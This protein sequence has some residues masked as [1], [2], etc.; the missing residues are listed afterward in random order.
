[1]ASW[2]AQTRRRRPALVRIPWSAPP[3]V[4]STAARPA[5]RAEGDSLWLAYRTQR[6][7]HFAVVRFSGVIEWRTVGSDEGSRRART[8]RRAGFPEPC[9]FQQIEGH[10][11]RADVR[12]WLVVFPDETLDVTAHRAHLVVRAIQASDA[13]GALSMAQA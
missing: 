5:T 2:T 13:E 3:T 9:T 4:H 1:M 12:R 6:A 10:D 7:D 8:E 11:R